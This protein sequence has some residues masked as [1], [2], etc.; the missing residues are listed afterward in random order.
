MKNF[1]FNLLDWIYKKKCYLCGSSKENKKICSKCYSKLQYSSLNLHKIISGCKVY[2]AG[3]Y[4]NELQKIIRGVKYH[5]QK[6]LAYFQAKFMYEYWKQLGESNKKFQ[7][8]PIPLFSGREKKRKY[9]HMFLVAEEFAKLS[10]YDVNNELVERIKDTKPQYKLNKAQR[11]ENLSSAFKIH[12]EKL[13]NCDILLFDDICT[14]GSTFENIIKEFKKHEIA[15]ILCFATT[16]PFSNEN[17]FE[18]F[19]LTATSAG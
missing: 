10:G 14:T 19:E 6:E 12:K 5:N 1:L 15:N 7:I 13:L 4:E 18:N 2:C 9:N 16:T 3:V 11:M 8:V 17:C